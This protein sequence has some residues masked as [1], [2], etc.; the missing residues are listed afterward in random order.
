MPT[1][2]PKAEAAWQRLQGY[3]EKTWQAIDEIDDAGGIAAL[4]A[5]WT[6][7][8]RDRALRSM[9]QTRTALDA[10]YQALKKAGRPASP[11]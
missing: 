9:A 2:N 5:G 11:K 4:A 1:P 10:A 7:K 6:P 8:A 3:L